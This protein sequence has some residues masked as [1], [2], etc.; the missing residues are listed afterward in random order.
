MVPPL[1]PA[2]RRAA[3][4]A[5][6]RDLGR[7]PGPDEEI[8]R[9]IVLAPA[10][11]SQWS[12]SHRLVHSL[13]PRERRRLGLALLRNPHDTLG[14]ICMEAALAQHP[15]GWS[16]EEAEELLALA[17]P[18]IDRTP[19]RTP[20]GFHRVCRCL[21]LP[22]AAVREQEPSERARYRPWLRAIVLGARDHHQ[23]APPGQRHWQRHRQCRWHLTVEEAA[24][25]LDLPYDREVLGR[26]PRV[27][28][29]GGAYG[30]RALTALGT[31]VFEPGVLDL[32]AVLRTID[33][34][35]PA[36]SWLGQVRE[37]LELLTVAPE[38]VG[39]LLRMDTSYLDHVTESLL[40]KQ[41]SVLDQ[42]KLMAGAA[43]AAC[44]CG[45]PALIESV[46]QQAL[47][48]SRERRLPGVQERDVLPVR[49]GV[50]A[51]SAAAGM[52]GLGRHRRALSGLPPEAATAARAALD[53]IAD[54]F[55]PEGA[56]EVS[57]HFHTAYLAVH[58]DGSVGVEVRTNR[59]QQVVTSYGMR[60]LN[61]VYVLEL[62]ALRLRLPLLAAQADR[63][64]GA[65]AELLATGAASTGERF[66]ALRLDH[67]VAGPLAQ[68]LV[69][70]AET[71]DGTFTGLPV[72]GLG[73]RWL[74]RD[75]RG[76]THEVTATDSVRLWNPVHADRA[77]TR[78]WQTH[79]ELGGLKQPI[80]QVPVRR[81]ASRRAVGDA[82]PPRPS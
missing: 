6:H 42:A 78:A 45:D 3:A 37:R 15:C 81:G 23:S 25:L 59:G 39:A 34:Y 35:R 30:N 21:G 7:H 8:R 68:A 24:G 46:A 69:W 53:S 1:P 75:T 64:R 19:D 80:R 58:P 4:R 48:R 10:D 18:E 60:H 56:R 14:D 2:L 62:T 12:N 72:R 41:A 82:R 38:V 29:G 79:L 47:G 71:A 11:P 61:G 70:E 17:L 27:L 13:E 33:S 31:L 40:S 67:D 49:A 57:L 9:G 66:A 20:Y 32:L 26:L 50:T 22:L 55:V 52:P 54:E 44:L 76:R 28:P 77:Q 5:R 65:L 51:L 43:W 74:L 63:E 73:G 36:Q 16:P